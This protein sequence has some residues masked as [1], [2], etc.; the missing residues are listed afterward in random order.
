MSFKKETKNEQ[1]WGLKM[2]LEQIK[3]TK[4]FNS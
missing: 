4:L 1:V 2:A 3:E